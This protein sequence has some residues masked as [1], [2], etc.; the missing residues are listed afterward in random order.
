MLPGD[1][2]ISGRLAFDVSAEGTGMSAGAL[3]GSL[4]GG[5]RFTLEN[6]KLGRLDPAAFEAVIRAVDRGL[7][8]DAN[9]VREKID[10]ALASGGFAIAR[11]DGS[12]VINAGQARL[13][14]TIARAQGADLAVG[15][16][17]DLADG[18]LEARLLL[19]GSGG[20]SPPLSARPEVTIALRGPVSAPRRTI[21]AAA[22]A[23]WLALRAVEQ[24]SKK[25]DALEGR[26]PSPPPP[27]APAVNS[28]VRPA[29]N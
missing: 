9:S 22:L 19:F 14:N 2:L 24:Q 28:N 1:G 25:L 8:I 12:I 7:P 3:I 27:G 21:D 13:S 6:G 26:E 29:P 11:A 4:E 5:G 20:A 10:S 15:G 17:V 23:N 18:T 16:S